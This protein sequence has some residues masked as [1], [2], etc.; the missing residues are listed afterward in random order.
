MGWRERGSH[1]NMVKHGRRR[2]EGRGPRKQ[3]K[4]PGGGGMDSGNRRRERMESHQR[5]HRV[6]VPSPN[7]GTVGQGTSP[8]IG[9]TG[10]SLASW[11]H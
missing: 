6:K 9:L 2:R 4:Q 8:T 7:I 10:L 11:P 5:K 3:D 1:C